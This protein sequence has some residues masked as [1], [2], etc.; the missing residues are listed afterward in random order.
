MQYR[1]KLASMAIAGA[2]FWFAIPARATDIILTTSG[3]SAGCTTS[4]FG[5]VDLQQNIDGISVDL[6]VTLDSDANGAYHFTKRRTL[7]TTPWPFIL[8]AVRM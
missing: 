6:T 1:R 5:M 7:T 3:C 4:P 8:A 2:V